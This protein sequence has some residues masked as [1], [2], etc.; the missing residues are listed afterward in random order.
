M[1]VRLAYEAAAL[2]NRAPYL[3][4]RCAR[5]S[6][7]RPHD[8]LVCVRASS[9]WYLSDAAD[10]ILGFQVLDRL[11]QPLG[12]AEELLVDRRERRVRLLRVR[13]KSG[14]PE[15]M[16]RLIPVDAVWRITD[17]D[18]SINRLRTHIFAGPAEIGDQPD[19]HDLE[20]IYA[21]YGYYPYWEPGYV[22]PSYPV[23]P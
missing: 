3:W 19:Q 12:V 8:Q 20:C 7:V 23:Y 11:D 15:G 18:V 14:S 6:A 13:A 1:A 4:A 16:T 17:R 5:E 9:R 10:D 22:Y 2:S 21:H